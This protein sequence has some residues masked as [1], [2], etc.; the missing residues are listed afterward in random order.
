[1]SVKIFLSV[2][3]LTAIATVT[4]FAYWLF[5]ILSRFNQAM[6]G[7]PLHN[8]TGDFEQRLNTWVGFLPTDALQ[9]AVVILAGVGV[10]LLWTTLATLVALQLRRRRQARQLREA[11]KARAM[12]AYNVQQ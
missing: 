11:S 8:P 9:R 3:A 2:I 7:A 6:G 5:P 4:G 10:Y 12:H 1:M